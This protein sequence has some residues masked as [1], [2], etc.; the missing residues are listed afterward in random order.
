MNASAERREHADP[1]VAQLVAHALDDDRAIV[2]HRA[3]RLFLIGEILQEVLGGA[4]VEIVFRDEALDRRRR[5]STRESRARVADG[6]A[7]GNRPL[8]GVAF[9]ER[10]L[11]GLA[12]RRRDDDAVVRDLLD[13]PRRCAE[14]ERLA[15][16]DLEDHLLIELADA[17]RLILLRAGEEH[18]VEAAIGN[19]AAVDDGDALRALPRA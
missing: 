2:G 6:F 10:H 4:A 17:R 18:A 7:K 11:A 5:A 9:P 12:R 1:P 8:R 3:G 19:R 13:A 15:G 14:E 16:A